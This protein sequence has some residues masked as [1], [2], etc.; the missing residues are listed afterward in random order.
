MMKE[1]VSL[2][3]YCFKTRRAWWFTALSKTKARYARTILGSLWLGISTLFTILCLGFIYGNVFK[4]ENLF[5]YFLYL[6]F[7]LLIWNSIC[8][9][10]NSA[11]LIFSRNESSIK[12]SKLSPLFFVCQ[13]WAF[14]I[15]N[16]LQAFAMVGGFF[17]ILSPG[18]VINL[19]YVPIH[20]VNFAL[21]IFWIPLLFAILGIKFTDLF[22][23]LPVITN[24]LFLLSPIL[25]E[26]K[27]LGRFSMIADYNPFYQ[28]LRLFRDGMMNGQLFLFE[29]FVL[30]L[31]NFI[32]LSLTI[33]LYNRVRQ[34]LVFYL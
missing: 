23:L 12:N 30:L 18:L 17:F 11:P 19:I 7:G 21:F 32:M 2:L 6:G 24:L 9:T 5:S 1:I 34:N 26:K 14:Q 27:N 10:I 29:G 15:Q 13:E 20:F 25:Y 16:F 4:V 31:I 33:I 22:Q 8:E 3:K 28:I